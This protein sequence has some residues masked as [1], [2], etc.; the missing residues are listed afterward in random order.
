[1]GMTKWIVVDLDGT[2][3]DCAHRVHLAQAK[4]WD[5]FHK[6][7]PEDKVREDVVFFL[8]EVAHDQNVHILLCTGRNEQYRKQTL[9]WLNAT[10]ACWFDDLIMRPKDNHESDDLLKVR[11]VDEFFGGRTKALEQ[12]AFVLD[13]R[14]RVVQSFRDAGYRC[15]QV[16]AG[17]Y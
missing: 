3:C 4:Q 15:W 11:M 10:D 6:G 17:A 5:E 2:L 7:I 14:D 9:D 12:V 16:A 1:M 13:D 8:D